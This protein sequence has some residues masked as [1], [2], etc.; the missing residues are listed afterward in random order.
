MLLRK[1]PIGLSILVLIISTIK[2]KCYKKLIHNESN[3]TNL[4]LNF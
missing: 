1:D 4:P 2:N 3:Q